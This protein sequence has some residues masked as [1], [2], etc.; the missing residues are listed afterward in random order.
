TDVIAMSLME[1]MTGRKLRQQHLKLT[2]G[3]KVL[4]SRIHHTLKTYKKHQLN[5]QILLAQDLLRSWVTLS[6]QTISLLLETSRKIP[7]LGSSWLLKELHQMTSTPTEL[8][9]VMM[10]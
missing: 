5:L 4:T 3:W 8:A 6:Q 7:L 10:M 2:I 1:Q 9:A